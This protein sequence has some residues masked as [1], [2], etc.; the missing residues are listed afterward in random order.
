MVVSGLGDE[1]NLVH[2][3][4]LGADNYLLKPVSEAHLLAR[5]RTQLNLH[6]DPVAPRSG[7]FRYGDL[8]LDL[9]HCQLVQNDRRWSLSN[10][11]IKVLTRLLHTPGQAVT[12]EELMTIWGEANRR[13]AR[14]FNI[15]P[16]SHCIYR[17]REKLKPADGR[18]LIETVRLVGFLILEPDE[19]LSELEDLEEEWS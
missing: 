14:W 2:G 17:L 8:I 12:N 18:E 10:T 11:E 1:A 9:G 16:L 6:R 4:S 7:R 15:R 3:L 5:V 19:T 13:G